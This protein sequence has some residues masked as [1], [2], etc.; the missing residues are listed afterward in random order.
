MQQY[1]DC[2][3]VMYCLF[4]YLDRMYTVLVNDQYSKHIS[5]F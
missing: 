1:Y 5:V 2:Q 4:W 3:Q